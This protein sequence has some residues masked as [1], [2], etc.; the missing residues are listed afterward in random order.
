ME[1]EQKDIIAAVMA[2]IGLLLLFI[3]A[4]L[5]GKIG[6]IVFFTVLGLLL[7]YTA[8]RNA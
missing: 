2:I 3:G 6:I 8:I 4:I 7:V 5:E 1:N